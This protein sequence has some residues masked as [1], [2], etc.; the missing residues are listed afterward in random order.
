M[1]STNCCF[2]LSKRASGGVVVVYYVLR[3]VSSTGKDKKG[4][5]VQPEYAQCMRSVSVAHGPCQ[6][7]PHANG[8]PLSP[9]N[10]LF[11]S[12]WPSMEMPA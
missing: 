1:I 2:V 5:P 9:S 11:E 3:V 6:W 12:D 7:I 8:P 10:E 4:S